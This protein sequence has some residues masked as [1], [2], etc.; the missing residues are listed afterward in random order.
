VLWSAPGAAH[1]APGRRPLHC[2]DHPLPYGAA[3]DGEAKSAGREGRLQVRRRGESL[4]N[5]HANP[6]HPLLAHTL[7]PT[8]SSSHPPHFSNLPLATDQLKLSKLWPDRRVR[9]AALDNKLLS[10]HP[11][12]CSNLLLATEQLK[13]LELWL[14]RRL[15]H[16][17]LH[18]R[19]LDSHLPPLPPALPT[20]F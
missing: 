19:L 4:A 9:H 8:A 17:A 20:S 10:T 1:A 13:L 5:C 16:A 18:A 14:D 6:S 11:P 3:S 12:L 7:L 2:T 15:Q